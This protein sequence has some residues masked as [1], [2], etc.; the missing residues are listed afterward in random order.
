MRGQVVD[1]TLG[2]SYTEKVVAR[3]YRYS[4]DMRYSVQKHKGIVECRMSKI[5]HSNY[6]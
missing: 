5:A 2:C 4:S 3:P 1:K 6:M